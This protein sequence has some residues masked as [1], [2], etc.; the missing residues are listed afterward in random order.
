MHTSLSLP[1]VGAHSNRP[2]EIAKERTIESTWPQ[3]LS[4]IL[5]VILRILVFASIVLWPW[6]TAE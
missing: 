3:T 1:V 5:V 2:K 4:V 6:E